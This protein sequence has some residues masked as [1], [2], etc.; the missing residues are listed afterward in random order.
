MAFGLDNDSCLN[1]EEGKEK[2][3]QAGIKDE[4]DVGRWIAKELQENKQED[5]SE[6]LLKFIAEKKSTT[7][8]PSKVSHCIIIVIS[9]CIPCKLQNPTLI[10]NEEIKV[11]SLKEYLL[12]CIF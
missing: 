1:S 8:H 10:I 9:V 3:V 5:L 7:L 4:V 12:F 11:F 2:L 6:R